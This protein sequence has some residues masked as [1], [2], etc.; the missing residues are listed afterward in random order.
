MM[1]RRP[2]SRLERIVEDMPVDGTREQLA[3]EILSG[4]VRRFPHLSVHEVALAFRSAVR[5]LRQA[6]DRMSEV[7]AEQPRLGHLD[8]R[9]RASIQRGARAAN[10][11]KNGAV[12]AAPKPPRY[13]K[14]SSIELLDAIRRYRKRHPDQTSVARAYRDIQPTIS[15]KAFRR[16]WAAATKEE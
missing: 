6:D 8:A 3:R 10:A 4:V 2:V 12:R 9:T 7:L 16:Y 1:R 5:Q 13:R 14:R 15:E 11:A